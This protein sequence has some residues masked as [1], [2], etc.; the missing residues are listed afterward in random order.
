MNNDIYISK[1]L[2]SQY[3]GISKL[4]YMQ[5]IMINNE[6]YYNKTNVTMFGSDDLSMRMSDFICIPEHRLV[7]DQ[8]VYFHEQQFL[9]YSSGCLNKKL[10]FNKEKELIFNYI[11]H[12]DYNTC[13]LQL[14]IYIR[15]GGKFVPCKK[16][17]C[18]CED[19]IGKCY[20]DVRLI[21]EPF[22]IALSGLNKSEIFKML[23][24]PDMFKRKLVSRNLGGVDFM[25]FTGNSK[26]VSD[27]CMTIVINGTEHYTK[28]ELVLRGVSRKKVDC[29]YLNGKLDCK[30]VFGYH[31][32]RYVDKKSDYVTMYALSRLSLYPFDVLNF[33][34]SKKTIIKSKRIKNK[35]TLYCTKFGKNPFVNAGFKSK[36]Y[37]I[38]NGMDIKTFKKFVHLLHL[39]K[40][41]G[42]NLYSL[43]KETNVL[44]FN[45]AT[46][47]TY[48]GLT[49]REF[50]SYRIKG[51]IIT[52]NTVYGKKHKYTFC[53]NAVHHKTILDNYE[54]TE[55]YDIT[56]AMFY[57]WRDNG[58]MRCNFHEPPV[59]TANIEQLDYKYIINVNGTKYYATEYF[60][61]RFDINKRYLKKFTDQPECKKYTKKYNSKMIVNYYT[62]IILNK[63]NDIIREGK[64][65]LS[66]E[67]IQTEHKLNN[68]K[69]Y[70][71]IFEKKIVQVTFNGYFMYYFP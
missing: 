40:K 43:E 68:F 67:I 54:Y 44:S 20:S 15:F 11:N 26:R 6:L 64:L 8:S 58:K 59:I 56:M 50:Y 21:P 32:Y 61:K 55:F 3:T 33:F 47:M 19:C 63:E 25:N 38:K 66:K 35:I 24:E 10:T 31:L 60:I 37:Y 34:K 49:L 30:R 41:P 12:P 71:L 48:Y 18:I 5:K 16:E 62:D 36:E 52:N 57:R 27:T 51:I 4:K 45:R 9:M 28:E 2:A 65:L 29:L 53:D 13:N 23:D 17:R 69:F 70:P 42:S 46:F 1:W 7:G 22:F 39:R 14:G